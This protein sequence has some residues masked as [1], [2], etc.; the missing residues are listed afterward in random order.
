[1]GARNCDLRVVCGTIGLVQQGGPELAGY[2]HFI[3]KFEMDSY[4]ITNQNTAKTQK[5]APVSTE[6]VTRPSVTLVLHGE[7]AEEPSG[8]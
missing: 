7:T 6:R 4:R 3:K 1:M 8:E 5:P 2:R